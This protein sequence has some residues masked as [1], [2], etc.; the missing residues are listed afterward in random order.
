VFFQFIGASLALAQEASLKYTTYTPDE[1]GGGAITSQIT[2]DRFNNLLIANEAGLLKFDG[3][4]WTQMPATQQAEYL[5]SVAI[6]AENRIWISGLQSIG[7][8]STDY[9]GAYQYKDMTDSILELD[10]SSRFGTFW[11]LYAHK[12][13]IYLITTS[14]V[15]RWDGES[16]QQ[17]EFE[18]NERILPSWVDESLYIH[19]RGSGVYRLHEGRLDLLADDA[20][21][22]SSGIISIIGDGDEALLFITVTDGLFRLVNGQ[23]KETATIPKKPRIFHATPIDN[24]YIALS[25][26]ENGILIINKSGQL[27]S[28]AF[29]QNTPSYYTFQHSS[30][31]L[32]VGTTGAI[33]DIPYQ[34]L[35]IYTDSAYDIVRHKETVYYTNGSALKAIDARAN[36]RQSLSLRSVPILWDLH[37]TDQN[38]LYGGSNLFGAYQDGETSTEILF[39]R[40]VGYFFPSWLDPEIIYTSDAPTISRWKYTLSGWAYL[41]SLSTFNARAISLVELPNSQLLIS[42]ESSPLLLVSWPIDPDDSGLTSMTPLTEAHGL[43]DKF[44]W[45]HCLRLGQTVIVITN[46]GLFRYDN[47]TERF[48]YDPVLGEDLGTDAYGLESCPSADKDGW[49]LRLPSTEAN[50]NQIGLLSI[51]ENN[52]FEWTPW[53]LPSLAVAGKVKALLHEKI[54]GIE[55]LWVGG[56]K[57][58]LHY[59][60][61]NMPDNPAPTT[62]LIRISEQS[63]L[64]TDYHGA[65]AVPA[66]IEWPYPQRTIRFEYAAPPSPLNV[67][68][69]Q[70]RL[71]GFAETWS[72]TAETT[73]REFTNLSHGDY[74]F[75]VR[76]VDEFGRPGK[77]TSLSFTIHPP[78]Y[79]TSYAYL[80]YFCAVIAALIVAGKVNRRRLRLRN[81]HLQRLVNERTIQ[82][83]DQ[84]LKLIKANKAKQNFL[85]SMSHEI[86][87]PLNGIIG[88]ARIL[89]EKENKQ[90]QPSEE[91]KYLHACSTHLHQL[92]GQ[93]LDYSSLEAGKLRPRTESFDLSA[94]L[95]EVLQ[96]QHE[97]ARKKG[98]ELIVNKPSINFQLIGDPVLLRQILINLISNGIKYTP[99]GSVSL[100]ANIKQLEDSAKTCFEVVDTG[101][102]IPKE[103]Q[104]L[105]FEEF[106]R[107]PE[108]EASQIPGT[109]LGLT[110]SSEMARLMGGQLILDGDYRGGAR[111]VLNIEFGIERFPTKIISDNKHGNPDTLKGKR[112]LVADDMDFNRYISA[113]VL[114]SMGAEIDQAEDG[115]IALNKLESAFYDI[116]I[117]DISMPKMTGLEVVEAFWKNHPDEGPE[118]I[119]LSAYNNPE[120]EADCIAAGFQFFIEKPLDPEKLKKILQHHSTHPSS[121]EE[122]LLS[123]LSKNGEVC[124]EELQARYIESF[125]EELELLKVALSKDDHKA[126]AEVIHKLLGLCRVQKNETIGDLVETISSRSKQKAPKDEIADLI[127]Q[128]SREID[129]EMDG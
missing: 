94:L 46:K 110:I 127:E 108:S 18:V 72:S 31:S 100:N 24:G 124:I 1:H 54:D 71:A 2:E 43:P 50:E 9:E 12:Q 67:I 92:L 101:P 62:R 99:S 88:I 59:D 86:R 7:Y 119:A 56:T 111:F 95:D 107:L 87:N 36:A 129:R 17:W 82:L 11:K 79:R 90:T 120:T 66:N 70:T 83:E 68:G 69:Y 60:L 89:R 64:R 81:T 52:Q 116:V 63:T 49:I 61:T 126:Q 13:Y 74:K 23:F 35:S 102:G 3:E 40:H 21:E 48:Q 32:W 93:T 44:I 55:T 29:H 65:G 33:L 5:S 25:T 97:M 118:F 30:G 15:L 53:P 28:Q 42:T 114:S 113:A 37:S 104:S 4:N 122:D 77:S 6:D 51:E 10:D 20:E 8:Y 103:Q 19:A 125:K 75:E 96:I 115:L 34:T 117:L 73:F 80:A 45:A 41:D 78:W 91:I 105:I 84:K 22:V 38:L 121:D 14:Y 26:A 98:I 109:G 39:S 57:N 128:L 123:Y 112:V 76:A 106:T 47:R 16:W 27:I 58:L 85:A